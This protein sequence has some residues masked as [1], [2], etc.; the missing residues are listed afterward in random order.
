M[1]YEFECAKLFADC[2]GRVQGESEEETL[3]AAAQH[4]KDMHGLDRLDAAT[5]A[6]VLEA[7]IHGER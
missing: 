5:E 3:A 1:G 2:P 6:R 7:M 4:A